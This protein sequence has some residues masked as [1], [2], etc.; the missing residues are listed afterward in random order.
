MSR[1]DRFWH[2]FLCG[3]ARFGL[4]FVHP[5]LRVEGQ[6]SI[7]KDGC[8]ICPNHYG[9]DDPLWTI[10]ALKQDHFF[11]VFAKEE[12]TSLPI[13]KHLFRYIQ[14]IGVRR[15]DAGDITALKVGIKA[16]RRN[17]KVLLYPEGTRVKGDR[18]SV[19]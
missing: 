13:L 2:G 11:P 10:F 17:E 14:L 9:M 16:L 1:T 12:V 15:G 3:L 18:K 5:I 4:F 8:I 19:V 7:P 6:E